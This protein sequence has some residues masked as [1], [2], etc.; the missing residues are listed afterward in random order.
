MNLIAAL[1]ACRD[2]PACRPFGAGDG[3]IE[4]ALSD[5]G[6]PRNRDWLTV[7]AVGTSS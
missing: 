4:I 6:Q 3:A 7:V 2:H 1:N 5:F